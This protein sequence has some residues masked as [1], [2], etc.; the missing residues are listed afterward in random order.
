MR[1]GFEYAREPEIEARDGKVKVVMIKMEADSQV[2]QNLDSN[3]HANKEIDEND[4]EMTCENP[5]LVWDLVV[6]N[7]GK[8]DAD[9]KYGFHRDTSLHSVFHE[10]LIPIL[11]QKMLPVVADYPHEG[12]SYQDILGLFSSPLATR[13]I[14][15]Y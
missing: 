4:S 2:K 3:H 7:P 11:L 5:E 10:N 12:F 9:D 13:L 1:D 14:G 8:S 6:R 15:L